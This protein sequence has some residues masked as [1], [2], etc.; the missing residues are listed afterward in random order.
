MELRAL[1]RRPRLH[2]LLLFSMLLQLLYLSIGTKGQRL[3]HS[4]PWEVQV[5]QWHMAVR[6]TKRVTLILPRLRL[7]PVSKLL[8]IASLAVTNRRTI[9]RHLH[10]HRIHTITTMP[11]IATGPTTQDHSIPLELGAPLVP[12]LP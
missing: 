3:P 4:L 5:K 9:S 12:R 1:P 10:P 8:R 11:T 6:Q 7:I 2:H